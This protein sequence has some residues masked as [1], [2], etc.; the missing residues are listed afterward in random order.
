MMK[1]NKEI[2]IG[3][4]NNA[5]ELYNKALAWKHDTDNREVW[6]KN[7]YTHGD[8]GQY[9]EAVESYNRALKIKS[10]YSDALHNHE[11]ALNKLGRQAKSVQ[12]IPGGVENARG[13]S[14]TESW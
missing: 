10:D 5:L 11:I 9:D 6:F 12:D 13:N 14:V 1:A 4:H 8:L 2:K 7:G 3:L